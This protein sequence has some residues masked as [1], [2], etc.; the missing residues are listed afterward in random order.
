[1]GIASAAG[2]G[3]SVLASD[4]D[5]DGNTDIFVANDASANMLWRNDGQGRFVDV[6]EPWGVAF[7]MNGDATAAM[8]A[9]R[10]D[11]DGDGLADLVVTDTAY[12]SLYR[13]MGGGLHVDD[14]FPSGI[15]AISGQYVSWG[16]GLLDVDADA[17]LDLLIV[18]GDLHRLTGW[19][20]LLLRNDG[21]GRFSDAADAS[22]YFDAKLMG[23]GAAFADYDN[24]GDV[25]VLIT[26]LMDRPV[27]LRNDAQRDNH[28]LTVVLEGP[29]GNTAGFGAKVTVRADDLAL[30]RELRCPTTY[31]GGSDPR[32]HFGLGAR[33]RVDSVEVRWPTGAVQVLEDVPAD[34]FLLV[35][36]PEG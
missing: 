10:G 27:L 18:N 33:A 35:R 29:P 21:A 28:W 15:A 12:G 16:G 30:T 4:M 32:L 3:M 11:C 24:D 17:D 14:V 7:G 23:R 5:G 31:L 22:A 36:W 19:E 2:R 8:T 25:D 1:S 9:D 20:D 13:A 6:A 26:N 34:R